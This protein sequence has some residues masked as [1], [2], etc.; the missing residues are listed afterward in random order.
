MV[1]RYIS[2]IKKAIELESPEIAK[3]WRAIRFIEEESCRKKIS[4]Q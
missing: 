3:D 2:R 1:G 4:Q